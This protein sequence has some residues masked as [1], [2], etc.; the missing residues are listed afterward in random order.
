MAEGH[1]AIFS[2]CQW[3]RQQMVHRGAAR[4]RCLP[5]ALARIEAGSW[6]FSTPPGRPR[7]TKVMQALR[8]AGQQAAFGRHLR[9]AAALS[10]TRTA[11]TGCITGLQAAVAPERR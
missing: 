6:L 3:H 11:T 4:D 8:S 2:A 1:P 7:Q 9:Q 5:W 10:G